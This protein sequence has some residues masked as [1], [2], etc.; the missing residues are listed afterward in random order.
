MWLVNWLI[1]R[2]SKILEWFGGSYNI[3]ISRLKNFWSHLRTYANM[4]FRWAKD[5]LWPGIYRYYYLG[6]DYAYAKYN[7]AIDWIN[8]KAFDLGGWIARTE[9]KVRN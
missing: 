7:Q 4:A 9:T 1:G 2:A 6:R 5:E 8:Q 3:W